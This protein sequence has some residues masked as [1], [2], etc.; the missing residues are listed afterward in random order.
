MSIKKYYRCKK[1]PFLLDAKVRQISCALKWW[2][3]RS[4]GRLYIALV[5]K[6]IGGANRVANRHLGTYSKKY[7]RMEFGMIAQIGKIGNRRV[8]FPRFSA[9]RF[10]DSE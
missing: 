3:R 6:L 4:L 5:A 8:D 10:R 9:G 1:L 7:S 2:Q